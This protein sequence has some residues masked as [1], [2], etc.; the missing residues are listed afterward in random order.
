MGKLR[1]SPVVKGVLIV[2][3][4]ASLMF[5]I[6]AIRRGGYRAPDVSW[7]CDDCGY[8]FGDRPGPSP[9]RCPSCGK[10]EAVR[11]RWYRCKECDEEFEVFRTKAVPLS[12][13]EVPTEAGGRLEYVK[14]PGGEWIREKT[15]EAEEIRHRY[16]CPEC[17]NDDRRQLEF[18]PAAE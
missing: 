8:G 9:Q 11:T 15:A 3:V 18:V 14:R 16:A 10:M 12:E 1:E 4:I 6:R 7:V 2:V 17:G 5:A 13:G